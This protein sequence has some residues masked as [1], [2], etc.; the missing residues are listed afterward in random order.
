MDIQAR[1]ISFVQEFL[2]LNS[3]EAIVSLEELL[4][5]LK[6]KPKKEAKP[7]SMKEFNARID[8]ALDDAE[9]GRVLTL[10]ELQKE[11]ASWS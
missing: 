10:D 1:K 11:M 4:K 7:M 3:E 2:K 9:N 6:S 5:Q 8:R